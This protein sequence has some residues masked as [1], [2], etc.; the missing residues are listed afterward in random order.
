[1]SSIKKTND[2]GVKV[3]TCAKCHRELVV[4]TNYQQKCCPQCLYKRHEAYIHRD[5]ELSPECLKFRANPKDSLLYD[6]HLPYCSKCKKW[7]ELRQ[8]SRST[9]D[10]FGTD[11]GENR[12]LGTSGGEDKKSF[13]SICPYCGCHLEKD[14]CPNPHC[15]G[16]FE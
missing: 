16:S 13:I 15:S 2:Y 1:M 3:L 5:D 4:P 8:Q 7:L 12:G 10:F 6:S 14:G 9:D 11:W